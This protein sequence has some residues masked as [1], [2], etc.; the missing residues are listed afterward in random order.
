MIGYI[1]WLGR[2]SMG[3]VTRV[4]LND[5]D[6]DDMDNNKNDDDDKYIE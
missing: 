5:N 3:Y 6:V 4:A 2:G 1:S